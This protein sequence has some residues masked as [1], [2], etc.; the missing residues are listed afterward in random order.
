MTISLSISL[1]PSVAAPG[2]PVTVTATLANSSGSP[3]VVTELRAGA[4]ALQ[5]T[6]MTMRCGIVVPP[7]GSIEAVYEV[8]AFEETQSVTLSAYSSDGQYA[9][10]VASLTIT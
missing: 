6:S 10:D 4:T 2:D 3:V 9:S 7:S 8:R 1:S 5:Q